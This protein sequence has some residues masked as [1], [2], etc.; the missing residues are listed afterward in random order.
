MSL[1]LK[2]F[3]DC[4]LYIVNNTEILL[5]IIFYLPH[6]LQVWHIVETQCLL[7]KKERN[8]QMMNRYICGVKILLNV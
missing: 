5:I 4:P 8:E 2:P 6:H 7:K 1:T 3:K